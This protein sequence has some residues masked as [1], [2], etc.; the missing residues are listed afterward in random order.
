MTGASG[1]ITALG[2][3]ILLVLVGRDSLA[4]NA[5]NSWPVYDVPRMKTVV[6]DGKT[7]DWGDGGF[8]IDLLQRPG[9][10]DAPAADHDS[11][12]RLGWNDSGLL[13]AVWIRDDKWV[14]H[15]KVE[16]LVKRDS[17]EVFLAPRRGAKDLCQWVISPGMAADQPKLRSHFRDHRKD[18]ALKKLPATI[19]AARSKTGDGCVV[20]A[21]LPW[22]ALCVKPG[23][24]RE[25]G[26]QVWVNDA[27]EP[28]GATNYHATW[29]PGVNVHRDTGR[30]RFS[31]WRSTW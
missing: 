16:E 26:F 19:R 6:I 28:R 22:K 5:A 20:E 21:V 12:V 18:E 27:D 7:D 2:V 1:R 29:H 4:A 25:V 13:V 10:D 31:G 23:I 17:V 9:G 8:R 30:I 15:P 24:G 11:S 14:E 3:G